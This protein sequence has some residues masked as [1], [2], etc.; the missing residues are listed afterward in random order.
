VREHEPT[1]R[2]NLNVKSSPKD[3]DLGTAGKSNAKAAKKFGVGY[4][5][6]AK[7]GQ[8]GQSIKRYR[9]ENGPLP[10]TFRWRNGRALSLIPSAL[11]TDPVPVF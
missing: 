5:R 2:A 10:V 8:R 11:N 9:R 6:L 7:G 4:R 1:L 3:D